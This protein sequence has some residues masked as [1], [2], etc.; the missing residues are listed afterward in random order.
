M[1]VVCLGG[2]PAGLYLA[3]SMK[4]RD[5]GHKITVI[6][7]NRANDTFGW[8]VVLS[9]DALGKMQDNDPKSTDAIRNQFIYWDDIAVVHD[10][11]RTVSGVHGFAGIGR[12]QMLV[13]LQARARNLGVDLQFQSKFASA[14]DYR[15]NYDLVV[16]TDGINSLVRREYARDFKPDIDMRLCKFIWLGTHQKFNDAFTLGIIYENPNP[17]LLVLANVLDVHGPHDGTD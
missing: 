5:P 14:E 17:S 12:K 8:G 7:Q 6:E 3:I 1:R 10:G 13:I 15:E 2:R 11:V 16:A 4:L 9:D